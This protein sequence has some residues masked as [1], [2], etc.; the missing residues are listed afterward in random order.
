MGAVE[1]GGVSF[2]PREIPAAA[3]LHVAGLASPHREDQLSAAFELLRAAGIEWDDWLSVS[4]ETDED[5]L[6]MIG[7]LLQVWSAR[8]W[9]STIMLA[10]ATVKQWSTIRGRLIDKG[11]TDPLRSIR[12][13]NALLDVVEVMLMDSAKDEDERKKLI[14]DLYPPVV[15]EAPPGDW[16]DDALLSQFPSM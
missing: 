10:S 5:P 11:I 13:M 3:A 7:K 9:K 8:P 1:F 14:R 4:L 15:G 6:E 12:S 16:S 2:T